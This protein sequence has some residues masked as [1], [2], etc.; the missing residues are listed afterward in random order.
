MAYSGVLLAWAQ[1]QVLT[2]ATAIAVE[3]ATEAA[4]T[5][6]AAVELLTHWEG[7][8]KCFFF[9]FCQQSGN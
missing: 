5:L 1:S 9:F 8:K 2:S 4:A 7:Q 6:P 3:I